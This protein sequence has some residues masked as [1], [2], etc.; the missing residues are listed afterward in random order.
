MSYRF[1]N[2]ALEQYLTKRS[3]AALPEYCERVAFVLSEEIRGYDFKETE[4]GGQV[5]VSMFEHSLTEVYAFVNWSVEIWNQ[6]MRSVHRSRK[7]STT[8]FITNTQL[9]DG[10]FPL[11]S[12]LI[13]FESWHEDSNLDDG[14]YLSLKKYPISSITEDPFATV[15]NLSAAVGLAVLD[16]LMSQ[17]KTI[18]NDAALYELG[19]AWE[20]AMLARWNNHMEMATHFEIESAREKM[21]RAARAR[22]SKDPRHK[23]KLQV[24]ELWQEWERSPSNYPSAAAF[25][26]DM[27]DKWPDLLTSEVVVSRWV[28]DWRKSIEK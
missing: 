27:C 14:P 3:Y 17:P 20:F 5:R 15:G 25:A 11:E 4:P 23:V 9:R 6:T 21:A 19:L 10:D 1:K 16:R 18:A 22:H 28:R 26:R 7:L 2:E 24:R 12:L 8:E 13:L